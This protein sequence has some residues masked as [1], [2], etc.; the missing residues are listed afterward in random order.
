MTPVDGLAEPFPLLDRQCGER[1]HCGRERA[2]LAAEDGDALRL[3]SGRIEPRH[4]VEP[5]EERV[6]DW[7]AGGFHEQC[8]LLSAIRYRSGYRSAHRLTDG[9]SPIA[10]SGPL[11]RSLREF[12]DLGKRVGIMHGEIR[13]DL[14]VDLDAGLLEP[15][16]EA[17]CSSDRGSGQRR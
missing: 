5:R 11:R 6:E 17:G 1:L 7:V 4:G 8:Y 10:D 2:L 15:R 14:P 13:Q 12:R 9:R 3:E 16:H